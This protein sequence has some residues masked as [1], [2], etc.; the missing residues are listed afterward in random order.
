MV[1]TIS[2]PTLFACASL[3]WSPGIGDPSVMGWATVAAYIVTAML[4]FLAPTKARS[5]TEARFWILV[6]IFLLAL[7]L[8]KQLDLQSALTALGRC[9]SQQQGWY[10]SRRAIQREFIVVLLTGSAFVGVAMVWLLRSVLG[11]IW[12][13]LAGVMIVMTF[14]AV[15]AVSFHHMDAILNIRIHDIRANWILELSGLVLIS[16]NAVALRLRRS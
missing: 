12:L 2:I 8:N 4:C 3:R 13:A 15:R 9:V 1:F 7:A 16:L 14:I 5:H 10:G 6:G 11:R